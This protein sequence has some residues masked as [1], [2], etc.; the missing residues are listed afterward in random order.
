MGRGNEQKVHG[1]SNVRWRFHRV[2]ELLGF[3]QGC[4]SRTGRYSIM[5]QRIIPYRV[6]GVP[7]NDLFVCGSDDLSEFGDKHRLRN[8]HDLSSSLAAVANLAI[9]ETT[10][11][12][13]GNDQA[14]LENT[15]WRCTI[16]L[17]L[18]NARQ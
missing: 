13:H 12:K 2:V 18:Y 1:D 16:M 7:E 5:G 10:K 9:Q 15:G 8:A 6:A 3:W 14:Y 11:Q 17:R 4:T